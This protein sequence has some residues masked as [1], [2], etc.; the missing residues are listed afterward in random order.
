MINAQFVN[1]EATESKDYYCADLPFAGEYNS[2]KFF[3]FANL[4]NIDFYR[5]FH[6]GLTIFIFRSDYFTVLL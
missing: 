1:Y 3:N 4:H 5:I 2:S 6:F